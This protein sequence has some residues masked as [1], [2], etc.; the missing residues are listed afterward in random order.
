MGHEKTLTGLIPALAG[1]NMI[2]GLGMV[3]SG[4]TFDYGQLVLD[5]EFARMIKHTLQG[6]PVNDDTIALDV[7]KEVGPAGEFLTHEHTFKGM[8]SQ[9]RPELIDRKSREVWENAG[10][11]TAHQR[12]MEKVKYILENHT[13]LPVPDD[14]LAK[15]RLIVEETE[16]EMAISG[17]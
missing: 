3:E 13:P 17:K 12:A 11:G 2:Y 1:A 15:I 5:C 10:A 7:I 4:I 16:A 8:R 14:V 9:S 6:I